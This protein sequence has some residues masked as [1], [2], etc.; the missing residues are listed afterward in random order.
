MSRVAG[1]VLPVTGGVD[2]NADMHVAAVVD[3]VGRVLGSE[4]FLA[5][6]AGYRAALAWLSS[7]GALAGVGVGEPAAVAPGWHATWPVA[8]S[9]WWR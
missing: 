5:S 1:Q 6:A 9:R 2:T 7:R 8:V 4:A 3:Q